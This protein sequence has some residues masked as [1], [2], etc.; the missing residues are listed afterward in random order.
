MHPD[1]SISNNSSNLVDESFL[2]ASDIPTRSFT[3]SSDKISFKKSC[4][5]TS[6]KYKNYNYANKALPKTQRLKNNAVF[7]FSIFL[8]V[9]FTFAGI[10]ELAAAAWS[11]EWPFLSQTMSS[12]GERD[13]N[14]DGYYY[15]T[16]SLVF[17]S[18][19]FTEFAVAF[20]T[21]VPRTA[22]DD[23][24]RAPLPVCTCRGRVM[25]LF[26]P[27][28]AARAAVI[29]LM[30]VA[31]PCAWLVAFFEENHGT[32]R[33]FGMDID[34][35]LIHGFGAAMA[36]AMPMVVSFTLSLSALLT[37]RAG[38]GPFETPAGQLVRI[39][40]TRGTARLVRFFFVTAIILVV[41]AVYL[42]ISGIM[43]EDTAPFFL[44][45]P[46]SEW[47]YT[48]MLLALLLLWVGV[49][50]VAY[51]T[52]VQLVPNVT[53]MGPAHAVLSSDEILGTACIQPANPFASPQLVA[54]E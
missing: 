26:M 50:A 23:V 24:R 8:S 28:P 52:N 29:A 11:A 40:H 25:R 43:D 27:V 2:G 38:P 48:F 39:E 51:F 37:L 1:S 46:F 18:V 3:P 31:M 47:V 17:F 45:W 44:C 54:V 53:L 15:F 32:Q 36:L 34:Q 42:G 19:L 21:V 10:L 14:P 22:P 33:V 30:L 6:R 7:V 41:T 12:L 35:Q 16:M 20:A 5:C 4:R 9:A 13:Q 49:F